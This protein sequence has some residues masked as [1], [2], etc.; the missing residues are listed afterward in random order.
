VLLLHAE[1]AP[2]L[3]AA[4]W[5]SWLSAAPPFAAATLLFP[6]VVA[7][8]TKKLLTV[9]WNTPLGATGAADAGA[10]VGAGAGA[11]PERGAGGLFPLIAVQPPTKLYFCQTLETPEPL[12]I[13]RYHAGG[14]KTLFTRG[15]LRKVR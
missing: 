7:D 3:P 6:A 15:E 10:G 2:L 8:L 1:P 4:A 13:L 12:N 11:G 9:R 14:Q 5:L